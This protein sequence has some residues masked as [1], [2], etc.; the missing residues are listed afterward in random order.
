MT[1]TQ[2]DEVENVVEADSS[3]E[4]ESQTEFPSDL[5]AAN[6]DPAFG[7]EVDVL[8]ETD[9]TSKGE[10]ANEELFEP[11]SDANLRTI[12]PVGLKDD[13]IDETLISAAVKFINEKANQS[14]YAAYEAIGR[15]LLVQFYNNDIAQATSR[16]PKKS[17]SYRA[18]CKREDLL[19][20]PDQFSVMIRVA[21][22]EDFFENNKVDSSQLTYTHKAELV[23]MP[24]DN[25]EQRAS[26]LDLVSRIVEEGLPTR[27][28][29]ELI[30]EKLQKAKPLP[31]SKAPMKL[32]ATINEL[33]K[34]DNLD[35]YDFTKDK[36]LK[37]PENSRRKLR[38][39]VAG[40]K[41]ELSHFLEKCDSLLM[42]LDELDKKLEAKKPV[43]RAD[44]R[45]I[46]TVVAPQQ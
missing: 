1:N 40:A 18:L 24:I 32:I 25:E 8:T 16:S 23:K 27:K 12:V 2:N 34:Q 29:H 17:S 4:N 43:K 15:Y 35:K 41:D 28:V 5:N 36:L 14:I 37:L 30:I 31:E 3:N 22:Q 13:V 10:S 20:R 19:F 9:Q 44:F 11:S 45:E 7:E 21:A 33:L 46:S 39:D 26:K 6:N 42:V 38:N